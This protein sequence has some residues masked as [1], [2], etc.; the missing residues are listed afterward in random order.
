[1]FLQE[2]YSMI[3]AKYYDNQSSNK[4]SNYTIRKGSFTPSYSSD[5]YIYL[6]SGSDWSQMSIPVVASTNDNWSFECKAQNTYTGDHYYLPLMLIQT[7]NSSNYISFMVYGSSIGSYGYG[8]PN[9]WF[10]PQENTSSHSLNTWYRMKW[11][12]N[13]GSLYYYFYDDSDN[14]LWSKSI[15][16]PSNYV[17]KE[18]YVCF[19]GYNRNSQFRIKEILFK[20]L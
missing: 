15:S 20:P 13:N 12:C 19:G 6:T 10:I 8:S 1:M 2:T 11:E 9:S 3:D 7:A 4:L 5:G 17:D 14:L 18:L 16:L